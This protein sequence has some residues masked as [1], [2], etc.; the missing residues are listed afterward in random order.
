M[1]RQER[2]E[3]LA[4]E[5]DKEWAGNLAPPHAPNNSDKLTRLTENMQKRGWMGPPLVVDLNKGGKGG[6]ILALGGSHR[7]TAAQALG[8]EV[9]V[10]DVDLTWE[11]WSEIDRLD[12]EGIAD[13]MQGIDPIAAEYLRE[14]IHDDDEWFTST[15]DQPT[16]AEKGE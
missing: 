7:I 2:K 13:L 14:A 5:F 9:P 8:I 10:Y 6:G 12:D 1:T 16:R 11:Q 15:F 3:I 4:A